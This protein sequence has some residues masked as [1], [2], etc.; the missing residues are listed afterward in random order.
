MITLDEPFTLG[1]DPVNA[2]LL[3]DGILEIEKAHEFMCHFLSHNMDNVEKI[4]DHLI[5]LR[6]RKNG[7]EWKVHEIRESFGPYEVILESGLSQQEVEEIE[8]VKK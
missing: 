2:E 7:F 6:K 1:L 5:M 4:C 3:K 8:G